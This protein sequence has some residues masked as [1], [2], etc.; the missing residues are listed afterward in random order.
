MFGKDVVKND[1][2][3][4]NKA[5]ADEDDG[6]NCSLSPPNNKEHKTSN[7]ENDTDKPSENCRITSKSMFLIRR[8]VSVVVCMGVDKEYIKILISS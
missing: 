6:W 5:N 7:E 3:I 8:R 2:N 1:D 4:S